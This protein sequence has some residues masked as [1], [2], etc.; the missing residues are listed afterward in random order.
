M[1][2]STNTEKPKKNLLFSEKIN[3]MLKEIKTYTK[4]DRVQYTTDV[5]ALLCRNI[6]E[7]E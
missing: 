3:R 2:E 7:N 4:A 5:K 1:E 6:E